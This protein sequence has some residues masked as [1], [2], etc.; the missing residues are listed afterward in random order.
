MCDLGQVVGTVQVCDL[1]Q[2]IGTV[3]VCDLGQVRQGDILRILGFPGKNFRLTRENF[4]ATQKI[5]TLGGNIFRPTGGGRSYGRT[6]CPP[7]P[8]V[9]K[10][11]VRP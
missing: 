10:S 9:K 7:P 1:G 5:W 3:Q 2:V 6:N 8:L 4:R 11:C